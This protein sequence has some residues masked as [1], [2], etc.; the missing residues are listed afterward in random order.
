MSS[1]L[2]ELLRRFLRLT[3]RGGAAGSKEKLPPAML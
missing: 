1:W 3:T 2:A